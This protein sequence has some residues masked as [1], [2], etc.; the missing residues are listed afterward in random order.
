[1]FLWETRKRRLLVP[2]VKRR[3]VGQRSSL[4][5][6]TDLRRD[7]STLTFGSGFSFAG[8]SR[9][10]G[11]RSKRKDHRVL[12]REELSRL[13]AI[14]APMTEGARS[15][16]RRGTFAHRSPWS[17]VKSQDVGPAKSG[18]LNEAKATVLHL[19]VSTH[20]VF[21]IQKRAIVFETRRRK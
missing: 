9:N 7:P 13:F 5:L 21:E 19:E 8:R 18:Q 20:A 2:P 14:S 17:L 16:R 11:L 1:M 4:L 6:T 15:F 3:P 10:E 12:R